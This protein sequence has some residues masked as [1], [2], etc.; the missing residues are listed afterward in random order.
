MRRRARTTVLA[1]ALVLAFTAGPLA[2]PALAATSADA[3]AFAAPASAAPASEGQHGGPDVAAL[4]KALEG[5]PDKDAT[6]AIVRVG[7]KGSWHGSAGVRDLRTG[8]KALENAR[9]RAGSTTKA[10]TAAV[11]LK[12]A[13]EGRIDL[14]GTVQSY[15]PGL[16]TDAFEPITVRQLLNYTSGLQGGKSLGDTVDEEYPH[17][18]ETLTP[19]EVVA[20]SVAKGPRH[21]PG[22]AQHYGNIHYLVLAMLIE[23]VTGDTYEHQAAVKVFKPLGMRHT[24]FPDGPDPRIHGP[25]NRGYEDMDG[26]LVD[27]TEWNMSDRWAAGDMIST[28]ADME[29][30]LVGLFSGRLLPQPQLK[31]MFTVP[32]VPGARYGAALERFEV[33]GREIWGKTGARPGYHAVLAATRDLSRTVVYSVTATSAKEDGLA[34]A[35]RFAFPAFNS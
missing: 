2:A 6:S 4:E 28:A 20:S 34:L 11:V 32:D 18:F 3:T 35:Q 7:G 23:K 30:L 21:A 24:S 26:K 27:V 17:R 13:A 8:A 29:R 5:L 22:A 19:E 33:N 25:H 1:T 16:L 14:D 10:V 31:E 15:L 12:L 9:F